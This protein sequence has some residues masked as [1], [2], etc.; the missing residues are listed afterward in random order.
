[1]ARSSI[2]QREKKRENLTEKYL[3]KRLTIKSRLKKDDL[4]TTLLTVTDIGAGE[5]AILSIDIDSSFNVINIKSTFCNRSTCFPTI[6]F[7]GV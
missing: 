6:Y 4:T 5:G 3:A 7:F 2:I 1:M